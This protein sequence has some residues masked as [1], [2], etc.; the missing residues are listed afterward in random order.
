MTDHVQGYQGCQQRGAHLHI[1]A[2]YVD[3]LP[4]ELVSLS[5]ARFSSFLRGGNRNGHP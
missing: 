2:F 1:G 3:I 4:K 5:P